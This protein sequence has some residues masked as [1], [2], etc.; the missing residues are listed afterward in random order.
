[1]VQFWFADEDF[2]AQLQFFW[3]K[4]ALQYLRYETMYYA[5]GLLRGHLRRESLLFPA[6]VLY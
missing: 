3:D 1:M 2:P 5:L 4:N 6:D